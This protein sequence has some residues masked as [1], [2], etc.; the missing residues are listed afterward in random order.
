[1]KEKIISI[2]KKLDNIEEEAIDLECLCE[3]IHKIAE[4][5]VI[6]EISSNMT[7]ISKI[8]K[9]NSAQVTEKIE[10]IEIDIDEL[11]KMI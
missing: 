11:L 4:N 2:R 10:E 7:P 5:D 9:E 6:Q 1:M 8:L 3:F